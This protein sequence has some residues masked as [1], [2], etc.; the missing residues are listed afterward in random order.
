MFFIFATI[1]ISVYVP[2]SKTTKSLLTY[3]TISEA[4]ETAKLVEY[5]FVAGFDD[6]SQSRLSGFEQI[7]DYFSTVSTVKV[8]A[9]NKKNAEELGK[10][11]EVSPDCVF[12]YVNGELVT[13]FPY[14]YDSSILLYFIENIIFKDKT[15]IKNVEDLMIETG[16]SPFSIFTSKKMQKDA[17]KLEFEALPKTGPININLVSEDLLKKMGIE[18]GEF[19]FFRAEDSMVV[20]Q[21]ND[22]QDL[23][24]NTFPVFRYITKDDIQSDETI[25]A[26]IDTELR[27]NYIDYLYAMG[28]S[29]PDTA[30]GFMSENILNK[31]QNMIPIDDFSYP[32]LL[33]FNGG[34]RITYNITKYVESINGQKFDSESW[35]K[36]SILMV[37]DLQQNLVEKNY[38]TEQV[39]EQ[40]NP[41]VYHLVGQTYEEFIN[42]P[43][44]DV[45]VLYKRENCPHC[46]K[47]F[48]KFIQLA[49]ECYDAKIETLRF[50]Y[51]DVQKNSAKTHFP[52]MQGVPHIHFFPQNK[53]NNQALYN[54]RTRD[55]VLRLIQLYSTNPLPL[56]IEP[57]DQSKVSVELF[58]LMYAIKD[59]PEEEQLKA[60]DYISKVAS[61]IKDDSP[62]D[63][64]EQK[65]ETD[66]QEEL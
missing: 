4:N 46:K 66:K 3:L 20:P 18:K 53:T 55:N 50:G 28:L 6:P 41:A 44:H 52:Y 7:A 14:P 25:V 29:F 1:C 34:E 37:Q 63:A 30:I 61:L 19:A 27:D 36:A 9:M 5:L 21:T 38:Y 10:G 39:P 45:V 58:Q 17:Y 13:A 47:Y 59:Y 42:D 62:E 33:V 8:A 32:A 49:Q 51:I 23:F 35:L 11:F 43:D 54:G 48:P 12:L 24:E 40:D 15:E 57:I 31:L 16:V 60:M 64:K 22:V 65:Q 2:V 56:E 26:L